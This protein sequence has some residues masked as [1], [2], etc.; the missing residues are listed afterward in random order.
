MGVLESIPAV[1]GG[2]AGTR[3]LSLRHSWFT[4]TSTWQNLGDK[5]LKYKLICVC[6]FIM[7]WWYFPDE[8]WN[9]DLR[10]IPGLLF[11]RY[12]SA[13]SFDTQVERLPPKTETVFFSSLLYQNFNT[14]Y[15]LLPKKVW[16]SACWRTK[17]NMSLLV[18]EADSILHLLLFKLNMKKSN[19]LS[20]AIHRSIAAVNNNLWCLARLYVSMCHSRVFLC[21]L[22][23]PMR[24]WDD[25][26]ERSVICACC[27]HWRCHTSHG[28]LLCLPWRPEVL[29]A[30][31]VSRLRMVGVWHR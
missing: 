14:F 19:T 6:F 2:E 16:S 1:T 4:S 9:M 12:A 27:I 25:R 10:I 23:V 13:L 31:S 20:K 18:N 24:A 3:R 5:L 7:K 30:V 26:Q 21:A 22:S 28:V 8:S 15:F 29:D 11:P 17:V